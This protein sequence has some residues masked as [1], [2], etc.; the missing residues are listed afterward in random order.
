MA[1][2]LVGPTAAFHTIAEAMPIAVAGDTIQL[3]SGYSNET[4]TIT[5]NGMIVTGGAT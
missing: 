4:A 2:L 5:H 3:Q 1:I